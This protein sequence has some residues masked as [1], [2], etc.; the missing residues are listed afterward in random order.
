MKPKPNN[1]VVVFYCSN[2]KNC[3]INNDGDKCKHKVGIDGRCTSSLASV[4]AM[5][6]KL[7]RLG[8][9]VC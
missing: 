9:D 7:K 4:N 8:V 6:I 5:V 1:C 2:E 3:V